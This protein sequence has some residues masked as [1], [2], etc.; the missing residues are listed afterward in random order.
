MTETVEL[1]V[2]RQQLDAGLELAAGARYVI[3]LVPGAWRA[4][5]TGMYFETEKCFL[6]PGALRNMRALVAFYEA[7]PNGQ[8]LVVGHTDTAGSPEHNLAL[9]IER[10]TAIAD[11]LRDDPGAWLEHFAK[12]RPK[13]ARWGCREVQHMLTALPPGAARFYKSAVDGLRGPGT[14]RAVESFQ[15]WSNRTRGT[16]LSADGLYGP[17]TNAELVAAYMA[18]DETTVPAGTV[19]SIQGCGEW[20]PAVVTGDGVSDPRNR[21]VELYFFE[22]QIEPAPAPCEDG[23]C[24]VYEDWTGQVVGTFDL[25]TATFV[26]PP[27]APDEWGPEDLAID[28]GFLDRLSEEI[29]ATGGV[30]DQADDARIFPRVYELEI[31]FGEGFNSRVELHLKFSFERNSGVAA[32]RT[33]GEQKR[34]LKLSG[35]GVAGA[36]AMSAWKTDVAEAKGVAGIDWLTAKVELELGEIESEF[37][38]E[39]ERGERGRFASLVTLAKVTFALEGTAPDNWAPG[40]EAKVTGEA[41]IKLGEIGPEELARILQSI[42]IEKRLLAINKRAG[43]MAKEAAEAAV[44]RGYR[45]GVRASKRRLLRDASGAVARGLRKEIEDLDREIA[46]L[47]RIEKKAAKA[48]E[49]LK[50]RAARL[51]KAGGALRK[52]M[53]TV[54]GKLLGKT[55]S[56]MAGK[57]AAKF[58]MK[59][60]PG[61][62]ILSIAWDLYEIGGL[63]YALIEGDAKF[64][65]GGGG[66]GGDGEVGGGPGGEL[67]EGVEFDSSV[68]AAEGGVPGEDFNPAGYDARRGEK[69]LDREAAEA[70]PEAPALH[71]RARQVL[72]LIT[73]TDGNGVAVTPESLRVLAAEIPGDMTRAQLD[74]LALRLRALKSD[75][76]DAVSDPEK[77]AAIA[78]KEAQYIRGGVDRKRALEEGSREEESAR[79]EIIPIDYERAARLNRKWEEVL[80]YAAGDLVG[81]DHDV[82]SPAFAD[83]VA[84]RQRGVVVDGIAGPITVELLLRAA[85]ETDSAAYRAAKAVLDRRAARAEGQGGEQGGSEGGLRSAEDLP[86]RLVSRP[87]YSLLRRG[88]GE[89][90]FEVDRAA[91]DRVSKL[92]IKLAGGLHIR[93]LDT[94]FDEIH[95]L[96][97]DG[98]RRIVVY[99][100]VH[101]VQVIAPYPEEMGEWTRG[102]VVD[103]GFKIWWDPAA[104]KGGDY[105]SGQA[106]NDAVVDRLSFDGEAWSVADDGETELFMLEGK[107][108]GVEQPH[109]E[110]PTGDGRVRHMVDVVVEPTRLY[111]H[112]KGVSVA[113]RGFVLFEV[114]VPFEV[115]VVEVL[116]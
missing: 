55:A 106:F 76:P 82:G 85:G 19:V 7:H 65:F 26:R 90:P 93:L 51:T 35:R 32:D 41:E 3:K 83:A 30:W 37:E 59:L 18:L 107:V 13:R 43:R 61:L 69:N 73:A 29:E 6:L 16:S 74:E 116:D 31:N 21:R 104:S 111:E 62:N 23:P 101:R 81:A 25:D 100:I 42:D 110:R 113:N 70:E 54:A 66:E 64:G 94:T 27:E 38:R 22:D 10:A 115:T 77:I 50:S 9:S 4:A 36:L 102:Q 108:V 103:E 58:L 68:S 96:Q 15:R 1:R 2:T 87:S 47:R 84:A 24:P 53:K 20:H 75:D 40:W 98:G 78:V 112:S 89:V 56:K 109:S 8:I 52:G 67:P 12:G 46:K 45:E 14:R 44:A 60:V 34:A 28:P 88:D 79:G 97:D 11:F 71:L 114:G 91:V 49:R 92:S 57:L 86:S 99:E 95:V 5:L 48:L 63:I 80:G 17:K 33:W 105:G 39:L 72:E